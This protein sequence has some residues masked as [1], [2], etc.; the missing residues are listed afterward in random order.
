MTRVSGDRSY[1][2][3][4]HALRSSRSYRAW[5]AL[6]ITQMPLDPGD[7]LDHL[8]GGDHSRTSRGHL[9]GMRVDQPDGRP[10]HPK[11]VDRV[12]HHRVGRAGP[13]GLVPV[14]HWVLDQPGVM[15]LGPM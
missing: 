6:L 2:D 10:R 7:R 4:L 9:D 5:L 15:V 8:H 1:V 13:P 3:G 12:R 11:E 14:D